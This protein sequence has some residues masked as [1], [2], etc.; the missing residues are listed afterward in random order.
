[1]ERYG[2]TCYVSNRTVSYDRVMLY[3]VALN[4][5]MQYHVVLYRIVS[6]R[7]IFYRIVFYSY[8]PSARAVAVKL[9]RGHM[10]KR[11]QGPILPIL[12][13]DRFGLIRSLLHD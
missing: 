5:T 4:H 10:T 13:L 1:M 6:F 2:T 9:D 3:S 11:D 12:A 7:N 8:Q